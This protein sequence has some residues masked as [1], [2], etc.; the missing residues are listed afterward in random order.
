MDYQDFV[1]ER[2]TL[3]KLWARETISHSAVKQSYLAHQM[4]MSEGRLSQ[5]LDLASDHPGLHVCNLPILC[6]ETKDLSIL[7]R[8]E[9]LFGRLAFCVPV[10]GEKDRCALVGRLLRQVGE[11][12]MVAGNGDDAKVIELGAEAMRCLACLIQVAGK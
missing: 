3:L 7:D 4:G 1:P 12:A 2:R 5:F 6:H 8:L 10:N 11:L 9:S